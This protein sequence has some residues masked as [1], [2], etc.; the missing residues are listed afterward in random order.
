MKQRN[1]RFIAGTLAVLFYGIHAGVLI[2][3]KEPYHLIWSCHLGCILVGAGL[4]I[5]Q[6]WLFSTGFFW[7]TMGVPLWILNVLTSDDFMLTSTFSHIGG[8]AIAICGLKL[9][10]MPRYSW[11]AATAGLVILGAISRSVTPEHA[12]VNLSFSVWKGWEETFPSYFW[13]VAM[14]LST[15]AIAF[16]VLEWMI[17]KFQPRLLG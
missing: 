1:N 6:P 5:P 10:K 4:L 14:L 8:I 16:F 9:L 15:A 17:R 2:H 7:L 3:G 13:Y 12:N 11:A